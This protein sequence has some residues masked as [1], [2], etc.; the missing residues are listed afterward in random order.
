M[1]QWGA[2]GMARRGAAYTD[3]LESFFPG[4]K[5]T[6]WGRHFGDTEAFAGG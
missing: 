3:I 1:S 4:T 2:Q 6:R 5:L